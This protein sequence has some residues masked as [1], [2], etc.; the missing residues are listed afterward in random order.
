MR[1]SLVTPA[2]R[3]AFTLVELLIVIVLFGIVMAALMKVVIGQQRFYRGAAEMV[4]TQGNVRDAAQVL[5]AELRGISPAQG[6]IVS[7]AAT[8]IEFWKPI[9]SAVVCQ[10]SPGV[11]AFIVPP[12]HL[13]A[14][15]G[16]TSWFNAP[17]RGDSVLIYDLG[18]SDAST[19]DAWVG[20][21]LS[22]DVTV[23]ATCPLTTGYTTSAAEE[24]LGW[25]VTVNRALDAL[26][27][28][29]IVQGSSVRFLRLVQYRLYEGGD[30]QWY[31]GYQ[32]CPGGTC[33][34][35][36]PVSGPYL[37]ASD[38]GV[39]FT[40]YDNTGTVTGTTT[41]VAR[42]DVTARAATRSSLDIP[43]FARAKR[44]DSLRTS[45]ALRN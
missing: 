26:P 2:P 4:E 29:N 7:M 18:S 24:D 16:L 3:R 36:Q 22:A 35:I 25:T 23:N 31:L 5:A 37:S 13:E 40:Y 39:T 38:G 12:E 8:S 11:A 9:G 42:I 20:F 10:L 41:A 30:G 32:E 19:D 44:V 34:T 1:T 6:D 14:G 21:S 43:G 33:E 28:Q 15:N 27:A 17:Q 45:I